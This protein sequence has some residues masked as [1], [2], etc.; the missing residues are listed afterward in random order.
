M[1]FGLSNEHIRIA[2]LTAQVEASDGGS[3]ITATRVATLGVFALGAQKKRPNAATLVLRGDDFAEV[4]DCGS[5]RAQAEQFAA[6]V[7]AISGA[8]A[9]ATVIRDAPNPMDQLR[10]L[11][12]LRDAGVI[13]M[14]E[15]KARKVPLAACVA[16]TCAA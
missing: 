12:A 15:F 6:R 8:Y 5:D 11:A 4:V 3:R 13:T 9:T 1:K 14:D 2:R 7:N 10:Q 16:A